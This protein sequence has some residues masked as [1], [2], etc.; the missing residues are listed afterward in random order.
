MVFVDE[1]GF[2]LQPMVMRTYAP[3]GKTPV[4]RHFLSRD[5][6]S[7]ISGIT[8]NGKL[9]MMVQK[10]AYKGPMSSTFS[11]TCSD[12]FPVSCWS[13]GTGHQFIAAR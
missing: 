2:Y 13:C 3:T 4:I 7:V 8:P 6:L 10:W 9:Y 11:A 1:S 5:H 12:T